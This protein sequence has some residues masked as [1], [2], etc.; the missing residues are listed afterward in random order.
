MEIGNRLGMTRHATGYDQ[1]AITMLILSGR[2]MIRLQANQAMK[3]DRLSAHKH[4]RS[5]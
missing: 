1:E 4:R 2:S 3:I 5:V